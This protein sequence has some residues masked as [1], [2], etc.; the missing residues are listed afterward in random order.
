MFTEQPLYRQLRPWLRNDYRLKL[1]G[2]D[3]LYAG[4][5]S[6]EQLTAGEGRVWLL[7]AGA[8]GESVRQAMNA[9]GT[10]LLAYQIEDVGT[11]NFYDFTGAGKAL[12]LSAMPGVIFTDPAV[13][14]VGLTES[15]ARDAGYEL[16]T[17]TLPLHYVPRAIAARDTR[18]L[19]KLVAEKGTGRLLGAHILAAD[20]GEVVQTAVLA[21]KFGLT[22]DDLTGTL[23]PYLTQVEGLKLAA[24]TFSKDPAML[25]CCAG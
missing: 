19:V 24:Q 14:T 6:P 25:S 8:Q 13:A 9:R 3:A 10:P 17:S 1:A 2:G 15:Q 20:A 5:P 16:E 7:A 21:V 18:G 22:L 12:D 23:F 4:A 11:L